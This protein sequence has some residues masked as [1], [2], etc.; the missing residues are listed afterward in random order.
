MA[1]KTKK[2]EKNRVIKLIEITEP[3]LLAECLYKLLLT[4]DLF[5]GKLVD[6]VQETLFNGYMEVQESLAKLQ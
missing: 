4:D 6:E 5:Y 1:K 3:E 2:E